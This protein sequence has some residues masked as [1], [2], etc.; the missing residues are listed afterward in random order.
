MSPACL[1]FIEYTVM[2]KHLVIKVFSNDPLQ[3][4]WVIEGCWPPL[5]FYLDPFLICSVLFLMDNQRTIKVSKDRSVFQYSWTRSKV[6]L[7]GVDWCFI[8]YLP[9]KRNLNVP[10]LCIVIRPHKE[11]GPFGFPARTVKSKE[12]ELA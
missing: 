8:R 11:K 10:W 9:K 1:S 7:C 6:P 5:K 3:V 2:F 4:Y 12:Q